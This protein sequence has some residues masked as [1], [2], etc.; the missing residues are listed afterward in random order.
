VNSTTG[1]GRHASII[2]ATDLSAP[3]DPSVKGHHHVAREVVLA[4]AGTAG[5]IGILWL[6]A[7]LL[8]GVGLIV[9]RTGSMAPTMPT[10][11]LALERPIAASAIVKGDVITVPDPGQQLPVTH[12]VVSVTQDPAVPAGRIVVLKGDDNAHADITPYHV[13]KAK[14]V[15]ASAP[16]LGTVLALSR[17]PLVLLVGTLL[18]AALV[19]WSLWPRATTDEQEEPAD[20][21][22]VARHAQLTR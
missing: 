1:G 18:F 6:I 11:A 21:P 13:T 12:R 20:P 7:T 22:T 16:Y 5:A 9:F 8:F 15:I 14:L 2:E 17:S 4:V 19:L 10:G 3:A